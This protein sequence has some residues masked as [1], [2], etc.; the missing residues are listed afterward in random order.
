[1]SAT[2]DLTSSLLGGPAII[3]TAELGTRF[4]PEHG[5]GR[6]HPFADVR[7][8]F[9]S[10]YDRGLGSSIDDPFG[11]PSPR[12]VNGPHYSRGFGAVAGVGTLYDLTNT[13]SLTTGVSVIRSDMST[14]DFQNVQGPTSFRMTAYRYTIGIRYNPIRMLRSAA[15]AL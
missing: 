11:N 9:T 10:A 15:P 13:F 1:M 8:G 4:H 2:L 5:E 3:Q 7:G 12:G 6:W 14:H